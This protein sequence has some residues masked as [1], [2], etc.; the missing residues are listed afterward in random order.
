MAKCGSL[1]TTGSRALVRKII[2][3]KLTSGLFLAIYFGAATILSSCQKTTLSNALQDGIVNGTTANGTEPFSNSVVGLATRSGTTYSIFCSGTLI[4]TNTVVT[5]AHC[6]TEMTGQNYVI[7]GLTTSSKVVQSRAVAKQ[8]AH[9]GYLP[10]SPD[11]AKDIFDIGVVQFEGAAPEGFH[12]VGILPYENM[13][14][15]G[16][17]VLL[18]GYG[19]DS[20]TTQSNSGT[21]RYTNVKIQNSVYGRTEV[22]TDETATGSCNGDSGGPAMIEVNGKYFVWG[23]T[24][25]GDSACAKDGIYTKITSYRGWIDQKL[26]GFAEHQY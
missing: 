20:G 17:E 22:M 26:R 11:D 23:T 2:F 5:A 16:S 6:L 21:L 3:Q 25:R 14:K 12:P 15:D 7:F 18:A 9:E 1:G 8:A 13:L 4:N 24:S 10:N 19:V